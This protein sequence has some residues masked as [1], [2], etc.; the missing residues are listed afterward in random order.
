MPVVLVGCVLGMVVSVGAHGRRPS[1]KRM[2]I[3]EQ[4][5]L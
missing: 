2:I 1:G 4:L 5:Y 3:L